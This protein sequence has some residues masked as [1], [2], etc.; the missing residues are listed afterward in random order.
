[1][2]P[3]CPVAVGDHVEDKS[4][5]TGVVVARRFENASEVCWGDDSRSVERHENLWVTSEKSEWRVK[6]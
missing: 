5:R 2:N 3:V 1:M 4:G 6:K